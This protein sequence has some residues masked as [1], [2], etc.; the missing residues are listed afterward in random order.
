MTPIFLFVIML[1]AGICCI[2]I[3]A[4]KKENGKAI[5]IIAGV[6]LCAVAAFGLFTAAL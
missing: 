4:K 5:I 6:V 1:I 2:A 3:G